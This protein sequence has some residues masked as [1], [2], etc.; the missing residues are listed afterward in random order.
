M[1]KLRTVLSATLL[2]GALILACEQVAALSI[3]EILGLDDKESATTD[4]AAANAP[5]AVEEK[6]DNKKTDAAD[7]NRARP[8]AAETAPGL[9]FT[10]IEQIFANLNA[11]QKRTY[12]Q[13]EATFKRFIHQQAGNLSVLTAAR[14]N[15]VDKD[16]N[17]IYLMQRGAESML[18]ESYL[19]K[20]IT[21]KLPADFP[22][23]QQVRDYYDKNRE[24]FVL[25]QRVH[26]W[27]IFLQT[28]KDMDAKKIAGLEN[29]AKSIIREIKQGKLDFAAAALKYSEHEPSRVNGGYM[30]LLKVSELKP[31]IDKPLMALAEGKISQPVK[32]DSGIH[33]LKRGAI[34]P[35]QEIAF[36]TLQ[37]QIAALL[38]KQAV[39]QLRQA[40]YDQA[41]KSYPVD[42][43]DKKIEE[44]RLRLRTNIPE[45]TAKKQ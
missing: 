42:L 6:R 32:T 13:D 26:V 7:P 45:T 30:G 21:S 18:R 29:K 5:A 25:E 14:A 8:G 15:H 11:G 22:T 41:E 10:D 43:K 36:A 39:A 12:L 4:T 23:E 44:W 37:P 20:L 31:G 19:S 27:Q 34:I 9:E 38:K 2:L 40:I 1:D 16:T 35:R 33:I 24:K 17:T 3:R 28:G